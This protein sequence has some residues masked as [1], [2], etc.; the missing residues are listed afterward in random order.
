[1]GK[2]PGAEYQKHRFESTVC[3]QHSTAL[4]PHSSSP[5]SSSSL[6]TFSSSSLSLSSLP[7]LLPLLLHRPDDAFVVYLSSIGREFPI[8]SNVFFPFL[9]DNDV[10]TDAVVEADDARTKVP[11]STIIINTTLNHY[12]YPCRN[13]IPSTTTS[14]PSALISSSSCSS[15]ATAVM[16]AAASAGVAV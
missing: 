5:S 6:S 11:T 15:S 4:Y 16:L 12:H 2:L 9:A 14:I 8:E 1:M 10:L 7:L 3:F 13:T